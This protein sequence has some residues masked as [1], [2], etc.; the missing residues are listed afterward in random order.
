MYQVQAVGKGKCK[1]RRIIIGKGETEQ[2][3]K[4]MWLY[5]S[6]MDP[7]FPCKLSCQWDIHCIK[8]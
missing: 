6:L 1:G 8:V 5:H 7:N 2:K 3:A 4:E